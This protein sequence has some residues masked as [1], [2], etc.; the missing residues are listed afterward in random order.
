MIKIHM[1]ICINIMF[2]ISAIFIFIFLSGCEQSV[3]KINEYND[4]LYNENEK[5]EYQS[6][7]Y[8]RTYTTYIYYAL[9]DYEHEADVYFEAVINI[10]YNK[11]P[12]YNYWKKTNKL[13]FNDYDKLNECFYNEIKE[14]VKGELI[15][16]GKGELSIKYIDLGDL[17]QDYVFYRYLANKKYIENIQMKSHLEI[18]DKNVDE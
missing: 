10:K 18:V 8:D 4:Y 12:N 15:S 2:F 9:H 7:D 3:D 17:V 16:N 11:H 5:I 14:F 6:R 1:R 13:K